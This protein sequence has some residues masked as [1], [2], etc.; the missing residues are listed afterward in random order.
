MKIAILGAGA[1]GLSTAFH[2]KDVPGVECTVFEATSRYGG[3]AGS[4]RWHDFY[5]DIAPHRLYTND[6]QLLADL[7]AL[8][9]M[10]KLR[11]RSRIYIRGKW[12]QDPVNA[13]E[14]VLKFIATHSASIVWHYLFRPQHPEHNFDALVLNKFGKG[15]NEFFF[16]P[17]SE[18]LFGIPADQISPSWGRQK[19]RVGGLRDMIRRNSKLYFNYFY[20]PTRHGYGAICQQWFQA[21]RDRVRFDT[22][23]VGLHP[24][25]NGRTL[26]CQF[27][28]PGATFT[29]SFDA[30]VSS[31]PAPFFLKCCGFDFNMRFRAAMIV[32]LLVNKPRVS[33]NHWFYLA[34]GDI[35][36]NRVAEFKNFAPHQAPADRTVLCCEVT[37]TDDFSV[38]RVIEALQR[39]KLIDRR[40]ILDSKVIQI[41]QAYPIYDLN[42]ESEMKRFQQWQ[43]R[44]PRL[45]HIGRQ[46]QFAHMDVDEIFQE[47]RA[48]AR[49]IRQSV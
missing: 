4:F 24:E 35:L 18:K 28:A 23:F 10:R 11:R 38:E 29:E 31:L 17:Y 40:Q 30:V 14:V 12:I 45:H 33:A 49:R 22:A 3:I 1:G 6:R 41:D 9:P 48:V 44:H 34:D 5:C 16:K 43:E 8:V 39:T 15:L 7:L 26:T 2:L 47:A 37:R 25:K 36:I 13:V 42:Y 20:Y 19:I 27:R 21:V 46:A 32:Y